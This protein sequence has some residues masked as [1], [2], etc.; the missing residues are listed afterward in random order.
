MTRFDRETMQLLWAES[1]FPCVTIY[2]PVLREGNEVVQTPVRLNTLLGQIKDHLRLENLTV[3]QID[4]LLEPASDLLDAP[5][6]WAYAREGLAIFCNDK[7]N[8]VL[9]LDHPVAEQVSIDDHFVLR[10][11]I[12]LD[13]QNAE[14]L[15]LAIARGGAK[16]YRGSRDRLVQIPVDDLPASLESVLTTY[17][18]EKQRNQYGGS[19]GAV[20]H[21]FENRKDRDQLMLEEYCRQIDTRILD[22]WRHENLPLVVAS[23]DYLFA[24]FRKISKNPLLLTKHI[25]GSPE[26]LSEVEHC[27]R[28]FALVKDSLPDHQAADWEMAQNHLGSSRIRDNI[29]QIIEVADRGQVAQLFLPKGHHLPG[30]FDEATRQI[31]H[32]EVETA[33]RPFDHN[34]LLEQ[35]AIKTMQNGGAVYTIAKDMLPQDADAL[36][37]LRY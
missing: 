36:A 5:L 32:P 15:L 24:T 26:H 14:Y 13:T 29:R 3:P 27:R 28:A 19:Y 37:V 2:L 17:A 16:I 1:G 18:F 11:L 10:P 4:K 12:E 7:T 35:A 9:S 6:F 33:E 30:R 20:N 25:P 31:R 34:D 8:L 22:H 21:G 23:V